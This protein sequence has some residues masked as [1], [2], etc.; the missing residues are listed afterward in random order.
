MMTICETSVSRN[1]LNVK[2]VASKIDRSPRWVWSAVAAGAFP[3][4]LKVGDRGARWIE[5]EIDAWIND[6]ALKRTR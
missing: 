3:S 6:L 1:L 2:R 5:T 4:P